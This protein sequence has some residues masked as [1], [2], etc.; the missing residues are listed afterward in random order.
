MER[1]IAIHLLNT[2]SKRQVETMNA[3]LAILEAMLARVLRTGAFALA[4]NPATTP[5]LDGTSAGLWPTVA[6]VPQ[7]HQGSER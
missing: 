1:S 5:K 6:S 4:H 7:G 2:A 3:M